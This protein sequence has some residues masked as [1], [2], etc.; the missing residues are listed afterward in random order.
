MFDFL[1]VARVV[2]LTVAD[3]MFALTATSV[4]FPNLTER[5]MNLITCSSIMNAEKFIELQEQMRENNEEVSDFLKDFG[6]WKQQVEL[7]NAHLQK[8]SSTG[9]QKLPAIRNSLFKKQ[10][11]VRVMIYQLLH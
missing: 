6:Y 9:N 11:K 3:L 5:Y 10:K 7:K 4:G 8:E 1:E 2:Q